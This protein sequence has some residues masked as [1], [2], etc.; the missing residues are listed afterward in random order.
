M[1]REGYVVSRRVAQRMPARDRGRRTSGWTLHRA[2]CSW[3]GRLKEPPYPAPLTPYS[4][5]VL[6]HY[7]K[8]DPDPSAESRS[9]DAQL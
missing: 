2:S 1:Y 5:T 8:P 3:L 7:C 4:G 6:C 9:T